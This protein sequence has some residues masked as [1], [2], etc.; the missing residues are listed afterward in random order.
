MAL[1]STGGGAAR[2]EMAGNMSQE[3][4]LYTPYYCEENI[5]Q[6]CQM[7]ALSQCQ[8]NV[9][10]ISNKEQSCPLWKQRAGAAIEGFVLWDYHVILLAK[11][12]AWEVWDLD[13]TL[14]LPTNFP[15]YIEETFQTKLYELAEH[16]PQFRVIERK[17][18][19][20]TFS[21]DRSHMRNAD[22]SWKAKPPTWPAI[23]GAPQSNLMQL[24]DMGQTDPGQVMNLAQFTVAF[25]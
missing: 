25:S 10:F 14:D 24:V 5:W 2:R 7:P 12:N 6:L 3:K 21:S 18:F 8:C 20:A 16:S 1:C 19:V 22:G 4:P 11:R 13:T 17:D 15:L 9:V 23:Q